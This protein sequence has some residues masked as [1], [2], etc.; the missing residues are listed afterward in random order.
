[1]PRSR[2][3][4]A[5]KFL[6]NRPDSL[7]RPMWPFRRKNPRI[8]PTA[9]TP[10]RR[11]ERAHDIALLLESFPD[12]AQ[13]S[14]HEALDRN[15]NDVMEAAADI[16]ESL[17]DL[18]PL[19]MC[20]VCL[21]EPRATRFNCGHASCCAECAHH[22]VASP[23][24]VC[25]ICRAPILCTIV[26]PGNR[27]VSRN[28]LQET[29][30]VLIGRQSSYEPPTNDSWWW[31]FAAAAPQHAAA[32]PQSPQAA[33]SSAGFMPA[34]TFA[35]RRP[36]YIFQTGPSGVGYYRDALQPEPAAAPRADESRRD[37]A[38]AAAEPT[39]PQPLPARQPTNGLVSWWRGARARLYL[40]VS[41][42]TPT[43]WA[44]GISFVWRWTP[45]VLFYFGMVWLQEYLFPPPPPSPPPPPYMPIAYAWPPSPPAPHAPLYTHHDLLA[46]LFYHI[47]S[48][49]GWLLLRFS[50]ASATMAGMAIAY[51]WNGVSYR[52]AVTPVH[53]HGANIDCC[54]EV[55]L[56]IISGIC[57]VLF[58]IIFYM[59]LAN[60][61]LIFGV[62]LSEF[63]KLIGVADISIFILNFL[64]GWQVFMAYARDNPQFVIPGTRP[65]RLNNGGLD[66]LMI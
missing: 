2:R 58:R 32:R 24:P 51:W 45:L 57:E 31:P 25:P 37:F 50:Q 40:H 4:V 3:R 16:L 39:P 15:N 29:S 64:V 46:T 54:T 38:P 34:P 23:T 65:R 6:S 35:G 42:C 17:N 53:V 10:T 1:M 21:V 41:S 36:G 13:E 8:Q 28:D 62:V 43:G 61:I 52:P 59:F 26:D 60:V 11:K 20:D 56:G 48:V 22:I 66:R 49:I 5:S 55:V 7:T 19:K 44:W 9:S 12:V 18:P 27:R 33:S 14:L 47:G 63:W 30:G